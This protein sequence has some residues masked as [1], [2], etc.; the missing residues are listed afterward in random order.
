MMGRSLRITSGTLFSLVIM[1]LVSG[2]CRPRVEPETPDYVEYGWELMAEESYREAV[3]QFEEGIDI[4]DTYADGHNGLGW[5]Y[6]KIGAADTSARKFTDGI[7]MSDTTIV[8]TELLAGRSFA[9][10]ALGQFSGAVSDAKA[11]LVLTSDWEF[12]RDLTVTHDDLTFTVAT[13]FYGLG[14]F[15]SSLVWVRK[16]NSDFTAN[17]ATMSGRSRLAAELEELEAEVRD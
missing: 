15:D 6:V 17:V 1:V 9:R 8:G 4:D 10:L 7:D 2:G 14:E 3:I 13:G 16:L 5:A 12:R 11:A